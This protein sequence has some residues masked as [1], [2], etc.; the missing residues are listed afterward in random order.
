[1]SSSTKAKKCRVLGPWLQPYCVP[2]LLRQT[3]LIKFTENFATSSFKVVF[4]KSKSNRAKTKAAGL[5]RQW[6]ISRPASRS[7]NRACTKRRRITPAINLDKGAFP[8]EG[9]A[10]WKGGGGGKRPLFQ[11]T[12]SSDPSPSFLFVP[13]FASFDPFSNFD[14]ND[15]SP[16]YEQREI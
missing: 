3:A 6:R 5:V 13:D 8:I 12:C 10:K 7:F 9:R 14:Q 2:Y 11:P 4:P 16:T 15:F 1:M